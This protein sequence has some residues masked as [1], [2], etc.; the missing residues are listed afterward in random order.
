MNYIPTLN[1]MCTRHNLTLCEEVIELCRSPR[2][3][4]MLGKTFKDKATSSRLSRLL[5][6][7][8][9]IGVLQL[10]EGLWRT[11]PRIDSAVN[12]R[13]FRVLPIGGLSAD[14]LKLFGAQEARRKRQ[15]GTGGF[16]EVKGPPATMTIKTLMIVLNVSREVLQ[17][18]LQKLV[19]LGLIVRQSKARP[20]HYELTKQGTES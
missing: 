4:R 10:D 5:F 15:K 7:M 13:P 18:R 3:R 9:E 19:E 11:S 17:L 2:S 20:F 14:I 8:K 12:G 1:Y 6:G 16:R